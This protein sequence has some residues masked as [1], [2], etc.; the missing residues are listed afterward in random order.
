MIIRLM[1]SG[2]VLLT[3]PAAHAQQFR[4][5]ETPLRELP[6]QLKQLEKADKPEPRKAPPGKLCLV[7]APERCGYEAELI[8]K[9]YTGGAE[10]YY[11]ERP[12]KPEQTPPAARSLK[13]APD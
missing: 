11:L 8:R 7:E 13:P 4:A 6:P 5:P 2:A 9:P 12:P 1:L 10:L 3:T